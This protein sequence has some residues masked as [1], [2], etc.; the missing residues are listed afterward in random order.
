MRDRVCL[1]RVCHL[2]GRRDR[3]WGVERVCWR[4]VSKA[5]ATGDYWAERRV[6]WKDD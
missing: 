6:G 1:E 2:T 4:V 3:R 5:D